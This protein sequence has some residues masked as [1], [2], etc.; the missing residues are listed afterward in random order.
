MPEYAARFA[1]N[2]VDVSV[3]PHL[4][5]RDLKEIG[6]VSLGH[7]RKLL[8]GIVELVQIPARA[9]PKPQD[10]AERRQLSI[11]FCDLVGSTSLSTRIDVEDLRAV[12][13]AYHACCERVIVENGGFVAKY[14]GDGV[15]AYFGYPHAGEHDAERAVRAGLSLVEAVPAL[16][17]AADTPLNVRVGIATGLVVVGDLLGSGAAQEQGVVG[18]TAN[19]AARL[20]ALA[21]PGAIVIAPETREL[22]GGLFEYRDLGAVALKGF[23]RSIRAWQVLGTETTE[24]RFEALRAKGTPL[25]GRDEEICLLHR[26]WEQAKNGNGRVVLL[27]GDAGVGKS[28]ILE[29]IIE[30]STDD[31]G[32]CLRYFC[33]PHHQDSALYPVVAQL[34]RAAGIRRNDP[35]GARLQ[36]LESALAGAADTAAETVPLLAELLGIPIGDG[37]PPLDL[38]PQARRNRTL[39]T[40]LD[41]TAGMAER[42][43][44]LMIFEDVHWSDPTTRALLNILIDRIPQRTFLVVTFRPEFVPPW[45][46]R[47]QLDL[48]RLGRLPPE[49]CVRMIGH[50]TGGRALPKEIAEQILERTD[51][52]PLFVE[53]LTKTVLESGLVRP[54]GNAFLATRLAV[55]TAVPATLQASL[56]ARLDR[57][58]RA[59]D[60]AQLGAALGRRFSYE[61]IGAVAELPREQI[62][63]GLARLEDAELIFRRGVPP[64]AEYVFKHALVQDAAYDTMLRDK[65]K[66]I[67]AR[68]A[69][70][71]DREFPEIRRSQPESLAR[72]CAE[73]G[74]TDEATDLYISA[75]RCATAASNNVEATAHLKR[76]MALVKTLPPTAPRTVELRNRIMMGGWWWWTT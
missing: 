28:R 62:D 30:R 16:E 66:R 38:P 23:D 25:I 33:S 44:V 26:R 11:M 13:G 35:D 6:V 57:L 55:T 9:D 50:L 65:R 32:A 5:D 24:S 4:T 14:M 21:D 18:E 73:A 71:L 69:A 45:E 64:N 2:D 72:H 60:L 59:R 74:Q 41:L 76:A 7:R 53:E 10:H 39:H 42:H 48:L 54:A 49:Q 3:L 52:V 56:L 17:T 68:I 61:L 40:I 1:E 8:A 36:K 27:S 29:S 19:L 47:P 67:H 22:T 37:Y 70:V 63:E 12:V 34:T 43:P 31:G 58:D 75:A 15:L 51:G 20:Q 46:G